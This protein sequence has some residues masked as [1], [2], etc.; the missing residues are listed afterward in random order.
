M[1]DKCLELNA[2]IERY[3]KLASAIADRLTVERVADLIRAM[4]ARKVQLH[5]EQKDEEA[6]AV[7]RRG[8]VTSGCG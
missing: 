1:C 3:R 8:S 7:P 2:K 5:S 6:P 4:E